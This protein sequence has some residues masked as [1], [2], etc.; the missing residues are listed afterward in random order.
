[1][2]SQPRT[3]IVDGRPVGL[4]DVAPELGEAMMNFMAVAYPGKVDLVMGS[5]AK[6]FA[7]NGG[8][9]AS[10]SPAVKQFA[11]YYGNPHMFSNALSLVQAAIVSQA[12]HIVR[13]PE[14][15][16][17]RARLQ[18]ICRDGGITLLVVEHD[19]HFV[20][21]I[22]RTVTVLHEG[23]VLAEGTMDRVRGDP[24]VVE[25]YLGR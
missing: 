11:K 4:S 18:G 17:L 7:S 6:T 1:M 10:R 12:I 14:G 2:S 22:A 16:E 19:M 21:S 13:A 24:R 23:K 25:V 8:F 20:D 3:T 15:D 9:L 5:F